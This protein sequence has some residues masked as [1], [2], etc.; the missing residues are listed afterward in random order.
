MTR[1]SPA[2]SVFRALAYVGI[3]GIVACGQQARSPTNLPAPVQSTTIGAGDLLEISIQ[4]EK[5][6]PKEYRVQPDGTVN[7]PYIGRMTILGLEPQQV[8]QAIE[9]RLDKDKIITNPHVIAVVKQYSSKKVSV[10][11]QVQKPGSYSWAD[12][13]TVVEAISQAGGFNSIADSKNV[14]LVRR[15]GKDKAVTVPIS[16]DAITEGQQPNI[17]LQAGDSIKVDQR[18]F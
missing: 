11:G 14:I 17:L 18:V 3:V 10:L 12:G 15:T 13:M 9:A 16:V 4:N 6:L 1:R 8:E 2:A 7:F 5:D